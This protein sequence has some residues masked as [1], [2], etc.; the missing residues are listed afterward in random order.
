MEPSGLSSPGGKVSS[1]GPCLH[2]KIPGNR[3]PEGPRR[4][5]DVDSFN[6]K[7]IVRILQLTGEE[8]C[9]EK[10][11]NLSKVTQD[12]NPAPWLP[13]LSSLNQSTGVK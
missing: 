3:R 1:H 6:C 4:Q 11:S 2:W 9:L 5:P 8:I 13:D 7:C 10:G 12:W